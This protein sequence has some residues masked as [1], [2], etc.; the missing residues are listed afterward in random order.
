MNKKSSSIT[1][2]MVVSAL[3]LFVIPI[4]LHAI[5]LLVP[6]FLPVPR[7][8]NGTIEVNKD[9]FP[10]LQVALDLIFYAL[11]RF[12]SLPIFYVLLY[13]FVFLS[14][15]VEK[16]KYELKNGAYRTE[17]KARKKAIELRELVEATEKAFCVF[18]ALYIT[19]LLLTSAL[20]I[21]SIV[22]KIE[23]V[24]SE[25]HTTYS[26]PGIAVESRLQML[27]IGSQNITV[28]QQR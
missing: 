23:T 4:S 24:I 15:E 22:E 1:V 26:M 7:Y 5:Q 27:D 19:M 13:M 6:E 2:F 21:F 16:F 25:N 28:I 10:P 18:L 12:L 3:C 14:S 8:R 9:P 20:E 11:T 17:H